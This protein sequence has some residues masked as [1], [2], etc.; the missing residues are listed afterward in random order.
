MMQQN[1]G[2]AIA[3]PLN[4]NMHISRLTYQLAIN[5]MVMVMIYV[6]L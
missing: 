3:L 4:H 5:Y 6:A 2:Y 1:I